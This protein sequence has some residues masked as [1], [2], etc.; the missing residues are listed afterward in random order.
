LLTK[1]PR[2]LALPSKHELDLL[3]S[4]VLIYNSYLYSDFVSTLGLDLFEEQTCTVLNDIYHTLMTWLRNYKQWCRGM[5][6]LRYRY[7]RPLIDEF[8]KLPE[9]QDEFNDFQER[10][11]KAKNALSRPVDAMVDLS[12]EVVQTLNLSARRKDGAT[13]LRRSRTRYKR[14]HTL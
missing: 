3:H 7:M 5:A 11:T 10:I 13:G 1:M 9:A 6:E 8:A 2:N 4:L 14:E 12:D